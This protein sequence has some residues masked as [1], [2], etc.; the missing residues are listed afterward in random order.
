M[1]ALRC[2][3]PQ[4]QI[5]RAVRR[6]SSLT[7]RTL[8]SRVWRSFVRSRCMRALIF[9]VSLLRAERC[10][11][12]L[13]VFFPTHVP[14]VI[15]ADPD[16]TETDPPISYPFAIGGYAKGAGGL[17]LCKAQCQKTWHVSS[18]LSFLPP[19]ISRLSPALVSRPV[20]E[21]T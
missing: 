20:W 3:Q 4:M 11:V 13:A 6:S 14:L 1:W 16:Q 5:T 10:C 19:L 9:S 7:A 15:G 2:C 21:T 18:R 17:F 8:V 12:C